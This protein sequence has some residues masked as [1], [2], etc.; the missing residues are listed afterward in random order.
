M[1]LPGLVDHLHGDEHACAGRDHN[2]S[3]RVDIAAAGCRIDGQGSRPLRRA[4]GRCNARRWRD[5]SLLRRA[6]GR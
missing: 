6:D 4:R 1:T 5:R 3:R 2:R